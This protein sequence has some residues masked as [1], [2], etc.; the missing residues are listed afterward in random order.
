M[1]DRKFGFKELGRFGFNFKRK[2]IREKL[3]YK[4]SMKLL[5]LILKRILKY[6]CVRFLEINGEKNLLINC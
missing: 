4:I 1:V 6:L 3:N 2:I 5:Y